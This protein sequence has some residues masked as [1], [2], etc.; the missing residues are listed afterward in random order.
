VRRVSDVTAAANG[1]TPQ[2]DAVIRSVRR[3]VVT[4]DLEP[5]DKLREVALATEV[6]VSR[7]TLREALNGLVQS[8]LLTHRPYRGYG[9][10]HLDAETLRDLASTRV[11]LDL[12]AIGA[13]RADPTG[14]RM[15]RLVKVWN[16]TAHRILH[17]DP[18]VQ[19][20]AHMEL[21][22]GVWE[23]SGNRM[24][25]RLWPVIESL[26]IIALA[27]DQA[28]HRDTLRAYRLHRDLVEAI[29]GGTIEEVERQL[30]VHTV[31]SAEQMIEAARADAGRA[32]G[33]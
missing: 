8:G 18:S 7:A 26:M 27:Q 13:I 14:R 3:A 20:E 19:H 1:T 23:A 22:L 24:L 28:A 25:M 33:S 17:E 15:D 21:H 30:A 6:G 2:R 29:T 10:T 4:G 12:I 9:V 16:T 31:E 5:G 11:S 32:A